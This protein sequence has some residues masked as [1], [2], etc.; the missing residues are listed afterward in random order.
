MIEGIPDYLKKG[1]GER[2]RKVI[3]YRLG[4]E[5]RKG[6]YWEEE[7]KRDCTLCGRKEETWEHVWERCRDWGYGKESWQ[8][9]IGWNLGEKGKGEE[10][11]EKSGKRKKG[12]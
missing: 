1:W 9:V 10:M 3:R 11:D 8:E 4:N 2:C 6:L 5:M 7:N 12:L